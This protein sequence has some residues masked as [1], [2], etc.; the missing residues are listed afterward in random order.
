MKGREGG[1]DSGEEKIE[2]RVWDVQEGGGEEGGK[3]K[4]RRRKDRWRRDGT[5]FT[6]TPHGSGSERSGTR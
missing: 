6:R 3:N 2:K 1:E 5:T 4:E